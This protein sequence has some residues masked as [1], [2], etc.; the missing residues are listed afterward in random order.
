MA[1]TSTTKQTNRIYNLFVEAGFKEDAQILQV[2]GVPAIGQSIA[3][4][5]HCKPDYE[6]DLATESQVYQYKKYLDAK[7]KVYRYLD[8][9]TAFTNDVAEYK[10]VRKLVSKLELPI[11][12]NSTK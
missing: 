6:K 10:K 11:G 7:K 9:K 4:L 1:T 12:I 3:I 2:N 5:D 8:A